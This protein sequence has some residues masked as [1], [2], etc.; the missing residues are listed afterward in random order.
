MPHTRIHSGAPWEPVVGYCRAV[1]AGP[2][3]AVAGTTAV[4]D[5]GELVGIGD[6]YAQ[7]RR[8][9]ELIEA[10]LIESGATLADVVR[11]RLYVTDIGRWEDIARA[12]R[13]VFGAAPPAATMVEV[14]RL[15]DERMLVEV[16]ADAI[17]A[18]ARRD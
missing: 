10:A 7:A 14:A 17:I 12:H 13:E 3:V 15:M 9:F 6:A 11:T 4:D 1:V 5:H 16:E 18:D 8:C 2:F